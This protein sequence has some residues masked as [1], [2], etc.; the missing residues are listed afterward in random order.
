MLSSEEAREELKDIDERI[1]GLDATRSRLFQDLRRVEASLR[2]ERARRAEI[3]NTN[4]PVGSLPPEI[5]AMVFQETEELQ[6]AEARPRFRAKI[7]SVSRR[8]R[9]VAVDLFRWWTDVHIKMSALE[10]K[11]LH[12]ILPEILARS[13]GAALALT[14]IFDCE[15][16]PSRCG[17]AMDLVSMHLHRLEEL[18]IILVE[19]AIP[20]A[21][22]KRLGP[23]HAPMLR[24]FTLNGSFRD[25][26]TDP[27]P[28][29]TTFFGGGSPSL[30]Q[31]HCIQF[32]PTLALPP[33]S[34]SITT[35]DI[36]ISRKN[37]SIDFP[38]LRPFFRSFPALEILR[39]TDNFVAAWP[40]NEIELSSDPAILPCLRSLSIAIG[41]S[42]SQY[43]VSNVLA[44]LAA[45]LL[46][47]VE[48]ENISAFDEALLEAFSPAANDVGPTRFPKVRT[49]SL[50][51]CD[52]D[53]PEVVSTWVLGSVF[54]EPSH[55]LFKGGAPEVDS[56]MLWSLFMAPNGRPYASEH[57][58]DVTIG[59]VDN[60]ALEV[61]C[62]ILDARKQRD[63][64]VPT[65][66][67]D[68][69]PEYSQA[70]LS[71]LRTLATVKE[72]ED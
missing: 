5:L 52:W 61:L 26:R 49:L 20:W 34:R 23:A 27:V 44:C 11:R 63:I 33:D 10:Y 48:L 9:S 62:E 35:L 64:L 59:C 56:A 38:E 22:L 42:S 30:Q 17:N 70:T 67:I 32:S 46:E 57:I 69:D 3:N 39:V 68:Q 71:R 24:R 65:I 13:K 29:D 72:M 18:T 21:A 25:K 53:S 2:A 58:R 14:L 43:L 31:L 4:I 16:S 6:S 41:T 54:Q 19:T 60:T 47:T 8:W 55:L 50:V 66:H 40:L 15:V 1:D 7:A 45:P 37:A 51:A 36:Y 12:T 28:D